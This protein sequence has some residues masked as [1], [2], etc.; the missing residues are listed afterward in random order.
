MNL[1][2]MIRDHNKLINLKED[3]IGSIICKKLLVPV[4][5]KFDGHVIAEEIYIKG[6]FDGYAQASTFYAEESAVLDGVIVA[7]KV[8]NK[9][10]NQNVRISTRLFKM[11]DPLFS[12]E[13]Q[14][15][16]LV[17]AAV[18]A[19]IA[20]ASVIGS[21]DIEISDSDFAEFNSAADEAV[22]NAV[23]TDI[24]GDVVVDIEANFASETVSH[25]IVTDIVLAPASTVS[26]R[27][28]LLP[29]LF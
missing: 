21:A 13:A 15:D 10:L 14:V 7:D 22:E 23:T 29:S 17:D 27:S 19:A 28:G 5:V 11:V 3:F 26:E 1:E 24:D 25:E 16:L 8:M 12:S 4:G 2:K 9:S 20:E 6:Q 18:E